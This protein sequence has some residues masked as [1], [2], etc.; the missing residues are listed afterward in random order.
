MP[1]PSMTSGQMRDLPSGVTSTG[2]RPSVPGHLFL[3]R[4][5]FG[6]KP[7]YYAEVDGTLVFASEIKSLLA[8][9]GISRDI[10]P[11]ALNS[12]LSFL[13]VPEPRTIFK[14]VCALPP[15]HSLTLKGGKVSIRHY[16]SFQPSTSQPLSRQD[17]VERIRA[18]F[19]DSVLSMLVS[20]VP[21]GL[22]LSGGIDS[23]SILS[24]MS[25]HVDGPVK[26]FSIGFSAKEKHWDELDVARRIASFFKTEHHEFHLE[27]DVVGLLPQ[28][29]QHFDQPFA[30]PT[31]VIL[32]LLSGEAR[33]HVKVALAGTGGD[34]MFAGYPRYVG[35]LLYQKYRHL[36]AFLRRRV[37]AVSHQLAH[38]SMD[39]R[40][41]PQRIRRFLEGGAMSFEDCYVR[42]LSD[43]EDGRIA[44]YV[45]AGISE[46]IEWR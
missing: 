9:P 33:Q 13:Y 39:G 46:F 25:R 24:M 21:L 4:D 36:P 37:A 17:A 34:E 45:H 18:A 44:G 38:D 41:W 10:D 35:M 29:V 43:Q 15:A 1:L 7:L 26:T 32:Y 30:N 8:V 19:E 12:Y 27:P 6:T 2:L 22:F 40:L 16:W 14:A 28:V 23:A 3:A 42:F 5:H 20:D 11:E 31:S